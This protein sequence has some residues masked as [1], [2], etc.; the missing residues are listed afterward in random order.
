M[1]ARRQA[2]VFCVLCQAER[3]G[4]ILVVKHLNLVILSLAALP[5][6]AVSTTAVPMRYTGTQ[7]AWWAGTQYWDRRREVKLRTI[8]KGPKAYDFVFVGGTVVQNWEGWCDPEDVAKVAQLHADGKLAYPNGPGWAV[9]TELA[10]RYRLLNVGMAGDTAQ[11]MLWR[12]QNG[13]LEGYK[14]KGVVLMPDF[15]NED[16][17]ED[18]AE[19]VKALLDRVAEYQPQ[20]I[21]LLTPPLPRG[22]RPN[23]P[24][25]IRTDRISA[26]IKGFADGR[27]V[28]WCDISGSFLAPDGTLRRDLMPD[29]RHPLGKGY[30]IWRDALLPHFRK[31]CGK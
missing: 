31:I 2:A 22:E 18:I 28:V 24:A 19:G 23:D 25:R 30:G 6:A 7:E 16:P 5:A 3:F 27:K 4:K 26:L 8:A 9:W 11:H 20:A 10:R 14:T 17:P 12:M 1:R 15:S 21:T 29:L 13:A